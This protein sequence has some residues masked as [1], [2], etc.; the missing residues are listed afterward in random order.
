VFA[1]LLALGLLDG[2]SAMLRESATL[3]GTL[4]G[5]TLA[6]GYLASGLLGAV[7]LA[8]RGLAATAWWLL[9]M[10]LHWVL[11]S[12]AAW[13]GLAHLIRDPYRWEKTEHGH[14]R[15]SRLEARPETSGRIL[16]DTGAGPRPR[17]PAFVSG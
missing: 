2:P 17:P 8:R 4:Y 14:A 9:L 3:P 16:R 5:I 15:T 11:L 1:I 12:I 6:A 13:R 10:P 7:G